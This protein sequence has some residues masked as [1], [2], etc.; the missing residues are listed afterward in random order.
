MVLRLPDHAHCEN[1]GDP[2]PMGETCCSEECR[3][4]AAD[5]R[6]A[7]RRSGYLMYI[8]IGLI[9]AAVVVISYF[10]T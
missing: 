4:S 9:L 7:D 5:T 1:C 10:V 8:S 2:V 3:V 6:A